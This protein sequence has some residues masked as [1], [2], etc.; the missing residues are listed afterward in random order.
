M[1]VVAVLKVLAFGDAVGA[2]EEVD[3]AGS[4]GRTAAFS[5]ERGEK[6]VSSDWKS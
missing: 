1:S 6:S 5:F 2:D 4:F 3:L